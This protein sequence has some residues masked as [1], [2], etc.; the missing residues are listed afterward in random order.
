MAEVERPDHVVGKRNHQEKTKKEKVIFE[1]AD[2]RKGECDYKDKSDCSNKSNFKKK[3]K[4]Y[5]EPPDIF[6]NQN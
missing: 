3:R 6:F 1:R 2:E 4:V 5:I